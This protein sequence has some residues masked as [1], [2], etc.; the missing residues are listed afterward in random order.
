MHAERLRYLEITLSEWLFRAIDSAEVLP[1]SR[2]YF[3]LR[4]PLDRRLYELARKH[5]GAKEKWRIGID[6]LQKKCGSKQE[7][8]HFVA[9]MRETVATNHLPDY[10]V[11]LDDDFVM[12]YKRE[13]ESPEA[14]LALAPPAPAAAPAQARPAANETDVN[15]SQ[16]DRAKY[17]SARQPLS[18]CGRCFRASMSIGWKTLMQTGPRK[19]KKPR[20]KTPVSGPGRRLL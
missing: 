3:R 15:T 18:R 10:R 20:T 19:R 17:L 14:K 2:D 4:R 5:C 6:K 1:I 13:A 8:K 7:R 12:F 9:H 16:P 11:E